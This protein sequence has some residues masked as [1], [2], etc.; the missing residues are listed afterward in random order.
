[1]HNIYVQE[2]KYDLEDIP[3]VDYHSNI[4]LGR[5]GMAWL[6]ALPT[7]VRPIATATSDC[8]NGGGC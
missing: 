8:S 6:L 2:A 7:A 3:T 1:M 4:V 5:R